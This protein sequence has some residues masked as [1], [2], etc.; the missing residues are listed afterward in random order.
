MHYE[1]SFKMIE[2]DYKA[3]LQDGFYVSPKTDTS[4][5]KHNYAEVHL[6]GEGRAEFL[7]DNQSITVNGP[8]ILTI[9]A[10]MMH[11]CTYQDEALL[12]TA[13]QTDCQAEELRTYPIDNGIV[14]AFF[15]A[16]QLCRLTGNYSTVAF[17]IPLFCNFYHKE[18][19]TVT[20]IK[21]YNFLISEFFILNYDKDVYLSDLADQLHISERHAE[22]LVL[23]YTGR[24]FRE[25]LVAVRMR[26][27]H[28]L[29]QAENASLEQIAKYVGYRSYSGFWK[30]M[31]RYESEHAQKQEVT[32]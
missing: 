32:V 20:E 4:L 26:I 3:F 31:K 12:H 1:L 5:H 29:M 11:C 7:I 23:Q 27:A 9:P 19:H 30:A 6:L 8:A 17:Y 13:F 2:K 15:E 24:S 22:R 10:P 28:Q 14:K 18:H 21:D 16:I 25:E